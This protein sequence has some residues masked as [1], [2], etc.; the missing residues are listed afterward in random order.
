MLCCRTGKDQYIVRTARQDCEGGLNYIRPARKDCE[1]S[2]IR[3]VRT[4]SGI[5]ERSEARRKS[6][7]RM[8]WYSRCY[9]VM[10]WGQRKWPSR[11]VIADSRGMAGRKGRM[12]SNP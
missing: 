3:P 7:S 10:E 4:I 9:V 8:Y 12:T 2:T 1:D 6:V 5:E 11:R